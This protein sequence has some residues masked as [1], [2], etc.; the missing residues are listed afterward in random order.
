MNNKILAGTALSAFAVLAWAAKDPVVMTVNGVDVPRSE[1][2]YLYH[3]NTQQQQLDPQ[4]IEE[5]AE[6]FKLYKLK[7]AD[8]L[9]EGIDTTASFRKDMAKYS[10]D[11]AEPYLADSTLL[12]SLVADAARLAQNEAEIK[13]IMT[14]KS[15]DNSVN[16]RNRQL[17]DSI[18][19][20]LVGG[21]DFADLA[22]RF[23]QDPS[24][25]T[26]HGTLGF[27][28]T[29]RL[30]YNFESVAFTLPEG[31]VSEVVES[32]MGYH[33]IVGGK[34]RPARGKVHASHIM[35]M[36]RPGSTPEQEA[37][38]KQQ[39]DSIYNLVI[40][41]PS[42]FEEF[43]LNLS[44]DKNSGRQ[45]GILPWFGA[46]EMVPEFDEAA[47][48]LANGAISAPVRSQFG[49]HIIKRLGYQQPK[50]LEQMKPEVLARIASPQDDR[51][52]VVKDAQ[53]KRLAAK[54]SAKVNE[55]VLGKLRDYASANGLDS[56]FYVKYTTAPAA[57]EA[58]A[59]IGK[60]PLTVGEF[61]DG[62]NKVAQ[63]DKEMA[64]KIIDN[65]FDGY[66]NIKL[67]EAEEKWLAAN[68]PDYR[69]LL[70]EYRDGSLLY[71]VSLQKVWNKA[72]QD[73]EG[74]EKFFNA[75]RGDYAWSEPHVKG[76]L[77]QAS[78]D[79]VAGLIRSRMKELGNDTVIATI[80]KEFP[81]QVQL[82][83]VLVKKGENA[84]VDNLMF[85]GN[86]VTPSNSRYTVYFL[87]DPKTLNEPENAADVR[88]KV[89]NDYQN[90][91]EAAWIEE[92]KSKYPVKM[93][94]KE[95]KKIK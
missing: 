11:L 86:P 84:M 68:E 12:N 2:E 92:L 7:V 35:K 49:W 91:L 6:M 69:N 61:V 54:H 33:V 40:E 90:E 29:G 79:S 38:A 4:P 83:R 70:N 23:S 9:A 76:I 43:A 66:Y 14:G 58:L 95:L 10:R 28:A 41:N 22:D 32:P 56:I 89:T 37:A 57:K 51:Y 26:N 13:H 34:K 81:R 46:G 65:Y 25:K 73:T 19:T 52:R 94:S 59:Y 75:H 67:V 31:E 53:T 82:D 8:A 85:G 74:L 77:V 30:P 27:F 78:N 24:A 5:Y 62:M 80:R 15:R 47:F 55:P 50:T 72:S 21:A 88:G 60:T 64:R 16:A 44:D 93:N 18:R 36:C 63:E 71:E 42:R 45:G 87:Y 17:I 3:K 48:A 39:I 20:L 1:F